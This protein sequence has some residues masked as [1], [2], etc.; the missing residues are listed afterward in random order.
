MSEAPKNVVLV[1]QEVAGGP[2]VSS[3]SNEGTSGISRKGR[4]RKCKRRQNRCDLL[5]KRRNTR[6]CVNLFMAKLFVRQEREGVSKKIVKGTTGV[7][8]L[9]KRVRKVFTKDVFT[10]ANK[11]VKEFEL[12]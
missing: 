12:H 6:R 11:T 5:H 7:I 8:E 1:V 4:S 10:C 3:V 9:Q 2:V